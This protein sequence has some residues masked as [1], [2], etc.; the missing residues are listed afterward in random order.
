MDRVRVVKR[1]WAV[2][3]HAITAINKPSDPR[4]Q[5]RNLG[6][7]VMTLEQIAIILSTMSFV[8]ALF[9]IWLARHHKQQARES[10]G[11]VR[12]TL[13]L[14]NEVVEHMNVVVEHVSVIVERIGEYTLKSTNAKDEELDSSPHNAPQS[15][16]VQQSSELPDK[17]QPKDVLTT[18]REDDQSA[19]LSD[20]LKHNFRKITSKIYASE[21]FTTVDRDLAVSLATDLAN[22]ELQDDPKILIALGELLSSFAAADLAMYIDLLDDMFSPLTLNDRT[23]NAPILINL[24]QRILS[25]DKPQK[26]VVD[27][28]VKHRDAARDHGNFVDALAPWVVYNYKQG[29]KS[30]LNDILEEIVGLREHYKRAIRGRMEHMSDTENWMREPTRQGEKIAQSYK[31]FLERYGE[32]LS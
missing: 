13:V 14:V 24:G 7:S 2:S 16:P 4:N 31:Q 29:Q 26:A 20:K 10:Y 1:G 8:L 17:E 32:K 27:R 5:L 6:Y 12:K 19:D 23:I 30:T 3:T 18:D 21:E 11:A 28:F 22:R 15:D 9:T 25:E